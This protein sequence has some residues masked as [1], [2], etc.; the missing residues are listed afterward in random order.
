MNLQKVLKAIS[1]ENRLRIL[2]L[3]NHKELCVCEIESISGMMQS[4]VSRHLIKL[5]EAELIESE[6]NGQFVFY[7]LNSEAVAS[8]PFL[9]DL[10][11]QE[12]A[13]LKL[14]QA[15]LQKLNE[16]SETGLMCIREECQKG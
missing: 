16:V 15:D 9:K 1:D 4:N 8:F 3:I 10:L 5:K 11:D 14:F 2:H 6:K 12:L 13:K 7:H